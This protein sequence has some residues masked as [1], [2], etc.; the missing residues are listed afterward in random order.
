MNAI[1]VAARLITAFDE[2]VAG[3]FADRDDGVTGAP[4][5]NIGTIAAGCR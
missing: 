4:T 2:E 3:G 5:H 1:A